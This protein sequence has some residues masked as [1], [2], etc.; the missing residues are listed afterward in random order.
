MLASGGS[1]YD[2]TTSSSHHRV[3]RDISPV[4]SDVRVE[5]RIVRRVVTEQE[6]EEEEEE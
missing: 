6:E 5:K 4:G 3:S 2:Y 1:D